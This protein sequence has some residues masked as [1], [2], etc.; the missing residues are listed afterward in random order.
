[1]F[2]NT[3]YENIS[4]ILNSKKIKYE[5]LNELFEGILPKDINKKQGKNVNIFIDVKSFIKQLY[6]PD[7][8]DLFSYIEGD[9]RLIIAS[10]LLNTIGHYRHYFASRHQMFTKFYFT[11]SYRK[12]EYH[13]NRFP[14]YCKDYYEK[15]NDMKHIVFHSLNSTIMYNLQIVKTICNYIPNA[16]FID[17]GSVDP[18]IVPSYIIENKSDPENDMNL[19][20]SNDRLYLQ[21]TL[22]PNTIVL[23]MRGSEKSKLISRDNIVEY[24]LESSKKNAAD[25]PNV[26]FNPILI[27]N[28]MV[29]FKDYQIP[30]VSRKS[31]STGL[32]LIDKAVSKENIDILNV[33]NGYNVAEMGTAFFSKEELAE[34]FKEHVYLTDHRIALNEKFKLIEGIVEGQILELKNNK[35]LME[36]N[37]TSFRKHPLILD[38]IF[39]GEVVR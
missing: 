6:N 31:Y 19:I 25:F 38:Y 1:M 35:D 24:L 17:S 12:S 5:K 30:S 32:S 3:A 37:E 8:I 21:E 29:G 7:T 26:T 10:E 34:E 20:L 2:D 28:G 23:E 14:D 33:H 27:L 15:R 18:S 36:V 39:E 16:H 9:N 22:Y 13:V 11:F 4:K